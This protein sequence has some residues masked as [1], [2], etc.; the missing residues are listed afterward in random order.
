MTLTKFLGALVLLLTW[1][2]FAFAQLPAQI[3]AD[4]ATA[5]KDE[6][7]K[8]RLELEGKAFKLA[9]SIA[10]EGAT[11]KL[12]ENRAFIL[13][14]SGDLLWKQD[15]KRA[16]NLFRD[17]AAEL[18]AANAESEKTENDS[19]MAMFGFMNS[20]RR[21]ILQT[22]AKRDAD[23]ALELL[24]QTRSAKVAAEMAK[25][26]QP[27][28]PA[29]KEEPPSPFGVG[30]SAQWQTREELRIEQYFAA[31]AAEQDPKRAAKIFRDSLSKGVSFEA[32]KIIER[33][34]KTDQELA[35]TLLAEVA[36]KLMDNDFSK[37]IW[38]DSFFAIELLSRYAQPTAA[39]VKDANQKKFA[40]KLDPKTARDLAG[41]IADGLMKATDLAASFQLARA[42]PTLEKILP[43]RIADLR[44]K[45]MQL[46][47]TIPEGM[48]ALENL[49]ALEDE[50][51]APEK[52]I[53]ESAKMP[54]GMRGMMYRRA[55][56]KLAEK[57]EAERAKQLL[58]SQ[59]AG[60]ERDDALA[61]VD[62]K[63]AEK[64]AKDGKFD[65]ARKLIQTIGT[66]TAQI[67]QLV[68]LAIVFHHKNDKESRETAVKIMDEARALIDQ[69]PQSDDEIQQLVQVVAGFAVID[70]PKAFTLLEPFVDQANELLQAAAL[71][72]KYQKGQQNYRDGELVM[73]TG[74]GQMRGQMRFVKELGLLA[75][76]DFER[77]RGLA[78]RFAR[79]D[80]RLLV[81]LMIAQSVLN[82]NQNIGDNFG[83]FGGATFTINN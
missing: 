14:M 38:Q 10:S 34:H 12:A 64:A 23:L 51:I 13:A 82:S 40:L 31:Q 30:L 28:Q 49:S 73:A 17:A 35:N 65:E 21:Q 41:K 19:P 83:S 60:K 66:K 18:I 67:E 56:D 26:A 46:K 22:I 52:I 47:K 4:S 15:Q 76:A 53:Q 11:L 33:I 29:Q 70:P 7:E 27:E 5:A 39:A 57:N 75:A 6:K 69:T 58:S 55:A 2:S 44:Q 9:E 36:Q 37:Q 32:T 50:S 1:C 59:P 45:R 72:A 48:D 74:L 16:R 79:A 71:L 25:A 81:R 43:E 63:L 8:A 54:A 68:K 20:P 42:M 24:V 77:T 80:T 78:D 62:G 3:S 61:Y